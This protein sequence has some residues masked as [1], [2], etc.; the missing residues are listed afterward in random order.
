MRASRVAWEVV[1]PAQAYAVGMWT[2]RLQPGLFPGVAPNDTMLVNTSL[3][4]AQHYFSV[5]RGALFL[6]QQALLAAD[7]EA[8]G[9]ILDFPCGHGRVLRWLRAKW[10][11]AEISAADIDGK[12]SEGPRAERAVIHH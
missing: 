10:P 11:D 12:H 1:R 9:R 4:E 6:V 5:G 2:R 8:P 3:R 7:N